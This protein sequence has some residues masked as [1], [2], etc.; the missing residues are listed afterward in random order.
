M[1]YEEIVRRANTKSSICPECGCFISSLLDCCPACEWEAEKKSS[2]DRARDSLVES[3]RALGGNSAVEKIAEIN[4][5]VCLTR[6]DYDYRRATDMLDRDTL[7]FV[8]N[9]TTDEYFRRQRCITF[10]DMEASRS[11]ITRIAS[12]DRLGDIRGLPGQVIYCADTNR[13]YVYYKDYQWQQLY[14]Y[15]PDIGRPVTLYKDNEPF[16]T[17]YVPHTDYTA[18]YKA[19][20]DALNAQQHTM[21]LYEDAIKAL[22]SYSDYEEWMMF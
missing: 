2:E 9:V 7:Y 12:A 3:Y 4:N 5:K 21:R 16:Y 19:K 11:Y 8:D 22:K 20:S 15:T 10:D 13:S 14:E 1:T 18:Y 17:E 6:V